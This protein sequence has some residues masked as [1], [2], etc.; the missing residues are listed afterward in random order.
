M[1]N[2]KK[3]SSTDT[4]RR[5]WLAGIGAYGRAFTE[6]QEAIKDVTGKSS[7]VFD[8]LVQKGEMIEMVVAAKRKDIV[9]KADKAVD[10]AMPDIKMPDLH[11]DERIKKMRSRLSG[12]DEG[13]SASSNLEDRLDALESKLDRVLAL[14]E[15]KSTVRKAMTKP[16]AKSKAKPTAKTKTTRTSTAKK[17]TSPKTPKS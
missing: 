2:E 9:E 15:P 13:S 11:I 10:K 17:T 16:V 3:R 1:A 7:E 5:I 8:D 12:S 6:A 4:A 14:L